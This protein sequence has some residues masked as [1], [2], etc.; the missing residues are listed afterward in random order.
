MPSRSESG[1]GHE[2]VGVVSSVVEDDEVV[3]EPDVDDGVVPVEPVDPGDVVVVDPGPPP[4]GA[5]SSGRAGRVSSGDVR[6]PGSS[7]DPGGSGRVCA[8]AGGPSDSGGPGDSG[9]ATGAAASSLSRPSPGLAG[10]YFRTPSTSPSTWMTPA[11]S[12]SG[13]L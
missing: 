9:G 4:G 1:P 5:T 10:S 3:V 7:A 8:R 11:R 6:V 12:L 2:V 13:S